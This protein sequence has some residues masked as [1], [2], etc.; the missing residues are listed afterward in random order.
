M[1][2]RLSDI[3]AGDCP[4]ALHRLCA[5]G[6][7]HGGLIVVDDALGRD[8]LADCAEG[9]GLRG[10]GDLVALVAQPIAQAIDRAVGTD[11]ANCGGC[12][13]RQKALN[14]AVPFGSVND[15]LKGS[16]TGL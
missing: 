1:T 7:V 12:K 6:Q 16:G 8:I 3:L 14:G 9:H 5:A 4:Q 15:A 10:L 13:G 11:L 2:I